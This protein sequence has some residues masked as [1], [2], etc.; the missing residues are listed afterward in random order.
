RLFELLRPWP[1]RHSDR[2]HGCR[3]RHIA[4]PGPAIFLWSSF[5][6]RPAGFGFPRNLLHTLAARCPSNQ[7]ANGD[8]RV[9]L[10]WPNDSPPTQELAGAIRRESSR[11]PQHLCCARNAATRPPDWCLGSRARLGWQQALRW[12]KT[13]S[14]IVR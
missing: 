10:S 8:L 2:E 7:E 11:K 13:R 1:H 14:P 5:E 9:V 4:Q 3:S 12:E 6:D